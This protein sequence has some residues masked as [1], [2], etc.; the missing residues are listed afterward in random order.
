MLEGPVSISIL[1]GQTMTLLMAEDTNVFSLRAMIA[2]RLG[3]APS[4]VKLLQS[5]Q[6]V[7]DDDCLFE[8]GVSAVVLPPQ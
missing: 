7:T 8:N 5:E 3:V 2:G 4:Q 1:S 6:I